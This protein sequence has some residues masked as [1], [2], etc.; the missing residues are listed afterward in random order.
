[1]TCG[2]YK[3]AFTGTD[4]VYIGKSTNI[5]VRYSRHKTKLR[6]GAHSRKLQEAYNMYG[7]PSMEVILECDEAELTSAELE[8]IDIWQATTYGLNIAKYDTGSGYSG[9]ATFGEEHHASKYTNAQIVEV[10]HK[11]IATPTIPIVDIAKETGMPIGTIGGISSGVSH[12]WLQIEYP[13]EYAILLAKKGTRCKKLEYPDIVNKDGTI[14]KV[15]SVS[16]TARALG[17]KR[18]H[19]SDVLNRRRTYVSGWKIC[20]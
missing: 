9:Y 10:L 8:A 1:M 15:T 2:I 18:S 14:V 7:E 5:E 16:E 19:L 12:K 4:R 3:L 13:D 11:L 17:I 6:Q 20:T